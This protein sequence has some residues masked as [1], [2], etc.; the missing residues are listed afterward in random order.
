M[1]YS[2]IFTVLVFLISCKSEKQVGINPENLKRIEVITPLGDTMYSYAVQDSLKLSNYH[3]ALDEYKRDPEDA[4]AI[5]WLGR[6]IGYMGRFREA[7]EIFAEGIEKHPDDA[8]MLRHRGHR[9]ISIREFDKA[10]KDLELASRLIQGKRNEIEPDGIPNEAGIPISTLHGNIYYH[11]ALAY[12]LNDDLDNAIRVYDLRTAID[13]NADNIVSSTHW[14]YM[15]LRRMGYHDEA[16]RLLQK[17]NGSMKVIENI[18]YWEMCLFYKGIL[19]ED[20]FDKK[21]E[22][23]ANKEVFLYGLGN[24]HLYETKDTVIARRYFTK[25]L[26]EGS[27]ASFAYIAAEADMSSM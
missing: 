15:A 11:L 27:K 3:L 16:K 18:S 20:W 2:L 12:Y 1:K 22:G 25:L 6:R 5:I 23:K 7:I 10:I 14:K 21:L 8:R 9:Y 17:V 4:E 24:W 19:K 13:A 26:K